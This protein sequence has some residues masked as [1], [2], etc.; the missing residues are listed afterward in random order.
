MRLIPWYRINFNVIATTTTTVQKIFS[1]MTERL[2]P[3][4]CRMMRFKCRAEIIGD[5][6]MSTSSKT[7]IG[8]VIFLQ[9]NCLFRKILGQLISWDYQSSLVA[10]NSDLFSRFFSVS[11]NKNCS[12]SPRFMPH[13]HNEN[14]EWII[15]RFFFY[16][17][18]LVS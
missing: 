5:Y 8:V 16:Y 15:V 12:C 9:N 13:T 3:H 17:F 11:E 10:Q 1:S 14:I 2:I 18:M 6:L 4:N 7:S